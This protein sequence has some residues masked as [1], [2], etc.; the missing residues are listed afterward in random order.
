MGESCLL[1]THVRNPKGQLV[2]SRLFNDLLSYLPWSSAK[3]Y[4][5]VG[6]NKEFLRSVRKKAKFDENGEITF[7]SLRKLA[8]INIS[9]E[10][11]ISRLDKEL[12]AGV[13]SYE[14][15]V[16]K[17][18]DFNKNSQY[19]EDY[20][21]T[22]E[23][24]NGQYNLH[25]I[26]RTAGKQAELQKTLEKQELMNTILNKLRGSGVDTNFITE[27][28]SR[29][30]TE[31]V[32]QMANGLYGLINVAHGEHV[33]T[34]LAEEAG[35]FAV[36]AL[37]R[38]PLV[39]RLMNL[40]NEEVQREILGDEYNKK[41][42][43]NNPR[44]EIAGMLVGQ[45]IH[46]KL[47]NTSPWEKIANRIVDV[48]KS[49]FHRLSGNDVKIAM[50]KA[51]RNARDIA[52]NFLS[53][54]FKGDIKNALSYK[55]TLYNAD[56]PYSVEVYKNAVESL[57]TM[58]RELEAISRDD[59]A[60]TI[61]S[62]IGNAVE[63]RSDIMSQP[64]GSELV[65]FQ[66]LCQML[67]DISDL[68][69]PGREIDNL[70]ESVDVDNTTDFNE[71][72]AAHGESLRKAR[73]FL[74]N[75]LHI[76]EAFDRA[77][78]SLDNNLVLPA[79]QSLENARFVDN[80]SRAHNINF[81]AMAADLLV[82]LR[83][84][85]KKLSNRES[86]FFLRF[87][88]DIYGETYI[89]TSAQ[90]VWKS[91]NRH[92]HSL[93][94]EDAKEVSIQHMLEHLETDI[95][96]F[97]RYIGSM[98][99]NP[100]VIGQ[101]LDKGLK[102]ANK[103]AD[104]RTLDVIKRLSILEDRL[105]EEYGLSDTSFLYERDDDGNLT[106]NFITPPDP[107]IMDDNDNAIAVNYGKWEKERYEDKKRFIAD[108]KER[109]PDWESWTGFRRGLEFNKEYKEHYK[110]WN[111]ENSI[112]VPIKDEFGEVIGQ[113]WRPNRKYAST[114]YN[115][116]INKYRDKK[117]K[118]TLSNWIGEFYSIK[119]ELDD[120][121]E[122]GAAH[123]W[124]APQ[125]KG[126]VSTRIANKMT[127]YSAAKST[128]LAMR[129]SFFETFCESSEDED[130]GS[131]NTFNNPE[132]DL[133]GIEM[134]FAKDRPNRI[135]VFGINRLQDMTQ[136]ST[137]AFHSMIAYASMASSYNA[138]STLVDS[139]EV[140]RSAL[141]Y[142]QIDGENI[143]EKD[144]AISKGHTRAYSRFL[145]FMDN[146]VYGIRS[147]HF[148]WT[149]R[150]HTWMWNKIAQALT[151]LASIRFLGGNVLG[152][153]VNTGTGFIEE[154]KEAASS[155]EYGLD[156]LR[157]AHWVYWSSLPS[158]W[159]HAGSLQKD[160]KMSLFIRHFNILGN[161]REVFRTR[162]RNKSRI[163]RLCEEGIFLP[164][165]A[166]DHYMQSMAYLALAHNTH[167]IGVKGAAIREL[168][169]WEAYNREEYSTRKTEKL[170]RK[171]SKYDLEFRGT[172]FTSAVG[173]DGITSKKLKE[174][175]MF[176]KSGSDL[177]EY[178]MLVDMLE[179]VEKSLESPLLGFSPSSEQQDYITNNKLDINNLDGI[180]TSIQNKI[181][182][183]LWTSA[184]ETAFM[185]KARE[186]NNRMHGIY[187][188]QDKTAFHG[189]WYTNAFLAMK[190]YALGMIERRFSAAHHSIALDTDVEGSINTMNKLWFSIFSKEINTNF[191]TAF[192]ATILAPFV[193]RKDC[194]TRN[195][196]IQAGFS[197]FQISNMKRNW[198]D[199]LMMMLL[200]LMRFLCAEPPEDERDDD[201]EP[202]QMKGY[203]YYFF[204]R[205][206]RE[207]EAFNVPW[208]IWTE[209]TT[210]MDFV[211]I[212]AV[213]IGDMAK[214][215]KEMG[216]SAI[217]DTEDSDY[218]YQ[219]D[220]PSGKYLEGDPKYWNHLKSFIPYVKSWYNIDNP[221]EALYSYEYGRKLSG[222]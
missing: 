14:E 128:G 120:L 150:K 209:S 129:E 33:D 221:Y 176:L 148:G 116:T 67:V 58:A 192:L 138:L 159:R 53:D 69:G 98:S 117:G 45:A 156:D 200:Y 213:V 158:N 42:L 165:S 169:L 130:Y 22:I 185:D 204:T 222:R 124:R 30:S 160:D 145:K 149:I 37:G 187:N 97:H 25:V 132:S 168:N 6:T 118:V 61:A 170:G 174:K 135:P 202:D 108:F 47:S 201:Y 43:G 83:N 126:V 219:R 32:E 195:K 16:P 71:R 21:A 94:A 106:G 57:G 24:K 101:I 56:L 81:K 173:P 85:D 17:L 182:S 105:K 210:L 65:A 217:G 51:R 119:K 74:T 35:H 136:L 139:L 111:E 38:S 88:Q 104:D 125:F 206:L 20:M 197:S 142:R 70:I 2:E 68:L 93:T 190:G 46:K 208:G 34:D 123:N 100:D 89:K 96:L 1:T 63:N 189:Q 5:G 205:W 171:L 66:G 27:G 7:N 59:L 28:S 72:M 73:V 91:K 218:F 29:Y 147:S 48:A 18:Q 84:T 127:T 179:Q 55:E 191:K 207:Q 114:Q 31:N 177:H 196:L 199:M 203:G 141:L 79:G 49:I 154:F 184:D 76:A 183:M 215:A 153:I 77:I 122:P 133:L 95:D 50:D 4:Y 216:G 92:S 54:N 198:M 12:G 151:K 115:D 155:D 10:K 121:L 180:R 39:E 80:L 167:L 178:N 90:I 102:A 166:G 134:D 11:L 146:Q 52:N 82:A 99:N 186:I 23:Y 15:A 9:E 112:Q 40:L 13:M 36:G 19:N 87:C 144:R 3:E 60:S 64:F 75:A 109:H 110:K 140:G 175:E 78:Y 103:T 193:L 62:F 8:N 211:P 137:D 181:F 214:L 164:Y 143:T 107:N 157:W 161:N 162:H 26:K 220:H 172:K 113:E 212:G 86:A 44:R 194:K 188:N 131:N 41:A 152:G 163:R